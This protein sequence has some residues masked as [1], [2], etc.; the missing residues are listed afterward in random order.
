MQSIY[1]NIKNRIPQFNYAVKENLHRISEKTAGRAFLF[2]PAV[3]VFSSII[4]IC[5][6]P[7]VSA[8]CH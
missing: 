4:I 1:D 3:S 2:P 5:L 6:F 8:Y 7:A